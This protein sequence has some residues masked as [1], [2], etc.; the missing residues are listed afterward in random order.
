MKFRI[1]F[2]VSATADAELIHEEITASSPQAA[3]RL[4]ALF[5]ASADSL[6][7]FPKRY[8]LAPESQTHSEEIRHMFVG[9]Y[10][11]LYKI[12]G[13]TVFVVRIRH[14]AQRPFKP[15]ELN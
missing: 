15:G 2:S 4:L 8:P 7:D 13:D 3:D 5:A 11:I 1:E 10:R 12:R 14:A 9:N 6:S